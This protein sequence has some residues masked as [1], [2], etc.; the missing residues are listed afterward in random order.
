M[1]RLQTIPKRPRLAVALL[2]A[3]AVSPGLADYP[4]TVLSQGLVGY[5]RM[6]E[7][8]QPLSYLVQAANQGSLAPSANGSYNSL[9]VRGLPCPLWPFVLCGGMSQ[10]QNNFASPEGV[11]AR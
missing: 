10:A 2:L 5:W 7:T 1:D 9:P 4:S 8:T 3:A 11:R 6:S